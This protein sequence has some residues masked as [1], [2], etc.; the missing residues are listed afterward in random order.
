[1]PDAAELAA[2]SR[3]SD[4]PGYAEAFDYT[5]TNAVGDKYVFG[6]GLSYDN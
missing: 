3:A 1:M 5:Y 6:F 4:V 2:R